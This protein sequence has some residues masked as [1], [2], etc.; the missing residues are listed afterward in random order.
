MTS[1]LA[2]ELPIVSVAARLAEDDSMHGVHFDDTCVLI[3]DPVAQSRIPRL[4][5]KSYSLP[6]WRKRSN[7]NPSADADVVLSTSPEGG[8]SITV[9]LP[10]SVPIDE[11]G[12]ASSPSLPQFFKIKV[13]Q[14]S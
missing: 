5:K 3:P 2:E 6:L 7:S 1:S 8:M 13:S 4:I 10:R 9:P 12:P 14:P 11:L